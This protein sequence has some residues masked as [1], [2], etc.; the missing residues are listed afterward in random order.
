MLEGDQD[1]VFDRLKEKI[2]TFRVPPK[3]AVKINLSSPPGHGK[4]RTDADI[5]SSA[6]E[7]MISYGCD[8]TIVEGANGHL[9]EN[10]SIIGLDRLLNEP[11]VHWLD[12]D[13]EDE[14]I[15]K[16]CHQRR[17]PLPKILADMDLR[18]AL[19][20]VTK[21][22]GYLFSGNVKT[23]VGILPRRLCR[24]GK[25]TSFSRPMIHD[26]LTETVSDLYLIVQETM[27]FH[28][29][30]NGGNT[31]SEYSDITSLPYCYFGTD[32]IELDEY[33]ADVLN[34]PVPGY[35]ARLKDMQCR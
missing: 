31:V 7:S 27:P 25:Q 23:F 28:I 26:D 15:W 11:T 21:R 35:L 3:V 33:L 18:I 20:A 19:P 1:R 13:M 30:I 6:V 17:Y 24:D 5:L 2:G 8:V 9:R 34:A 4:V 12:L 29:F 10:L 22:P 14:I 32:P 16:E